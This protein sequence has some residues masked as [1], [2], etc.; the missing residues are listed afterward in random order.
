[1]DIAVLEV[2]EVSPKLH[3]VENVCV[4]RAHV[5]AELAVEPVDLLE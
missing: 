5:H 4:V 3:A 2:L 1:V